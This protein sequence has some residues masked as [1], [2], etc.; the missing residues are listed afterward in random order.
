MFSA[1]KK[2]LDTLLFRLYKTFFQRKKFRENFIKFILMFP[3]GEKAVF[4]SYI[5]ILSGIFVAANSIKILTICAS[6]YSKHSF[7]T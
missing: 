7:E 3:V 5:G 6:A 2:R 4:E 1:S